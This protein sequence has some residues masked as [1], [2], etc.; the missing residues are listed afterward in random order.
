M[1][2]EI[3]GAMDACAVLVFRDQRFD[4]GE[5]LAFARGFDGTLHAKTGAC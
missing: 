1:L 5:Q 3:R 4:G 2:D